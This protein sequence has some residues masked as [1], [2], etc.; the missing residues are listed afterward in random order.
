MK[1]SQLRTV[2]F[3][4]IGGA[5][6]SG[7]ARIALEAGARVSGSDLVCNPTMRD[8]AEGGAT[9]YTDHHRD[10]V[11]A[12]CQLVVVS[13][14]IKK[15]NPEYREA[16]RRGIRIMKYAEALGELTRAHTNLCI[17]GTHGKTTTTAMLAQMMVDGG[18]E[19]GYL[20]GGEPASLPSASAA[21]NGVNFVI[22]SCEYDRSFLRLHPGVI[23]LNNIELDHMDVYG[24]IE[25]V[26]K[27]FVEFARRLPERGTLFF[28][29]DDPH[30]VEVARRSRVN[31]VS[32]GEGKDA[33][34]RLHNIDTSTG[35]AVA[36]V[37]CRD[38]QV[39]RM[40]LQ[41]PGRVNTMNAL[42]ALAAANWSGVPV[43]RALKALR[44]FGGVKRRF[45]VVGS[46]GG[47]PLVDDYAHHPTAVKQ[48]L[49]TAR[50][51]FINRRVIAV[52][53]AHQY[54]RILGFFDGFVDA[55]KLADR[56]LVARTYAARESGIQPGVHEERLART[57]RQ[58]NVDAMSYGDF[59]AIA[60]DLTAKTTPRDVLLFIGAGDVNEIAYEMLQ[61]RDVISSRLRAIKPEEV[62]A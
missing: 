55:L 29:A 58:D 50:A 3:V 24:N 35:F 23:V 36:D 32:F 26:I 61:R 46:V 4:G 31:A 54:Q 12:E 22:E 43:H 52:F 60:N 48:L 39:G 30:C 13:A 38:M 16:T 10:H 59:T 1:L 41:V 6:V 14:A 5:G 56:V 62:A 45:E 44:N 2:H 8:L 25:G 34:W 47:V 53:Q 28:N 27:G 21:G 18:K 17:G 33:V 40:Q 19:P 57:L 51:A 7:L 20:V 11:P 42:G 15:A 49:E 37:T 9:I